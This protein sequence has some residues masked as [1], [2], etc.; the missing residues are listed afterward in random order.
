MSTV[1][2]YLSLPSLDERMFFSVDHEF[3]DLNTKVQSFEEAVSNLEDIFV[4]GDS[5]SLAAV[6]KLVLQFNTE[7]I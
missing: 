7:V 4:H 5:L 3:G 1:D 2:T 6:E